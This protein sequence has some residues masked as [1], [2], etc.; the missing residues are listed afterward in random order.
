MR[1]LPIAPPPTR[2]RSGDPQS[3]GRFLAPAIVRLAGT[4]SNRA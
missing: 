3:T 4:V 2:R 1:N